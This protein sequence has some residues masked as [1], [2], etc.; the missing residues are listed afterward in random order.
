LLWGDGV[1]NTGEISPIA[2]FVF[3]FVREVDDI[4]IGETFIMGFCKRV[5]KFLANYPKFRTL[6]TE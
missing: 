6:T 1:F 2:I 5:T 4:V 3:Y